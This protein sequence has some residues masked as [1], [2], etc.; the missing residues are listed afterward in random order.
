MERALR[1]IGIVLAGQQREQ[2]D[3][4]QAMNGDLL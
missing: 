3:L 2:L 4:I 1:F